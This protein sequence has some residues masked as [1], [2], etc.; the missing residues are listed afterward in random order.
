MKLV[1]NGAEVPKDQYTGA[2]GTQIDIDVVDVSGFGLPLPKVSQQYV[3]TGAAFDTVNSLII[4]NPNGKNASIPVK[5]YEDSCCEDDVLLFEGIIRGDMVDWCYGECQC[6]VT[7]K[8]ETEESLKVQC[9]KSTLIWDNWNGFQTDDHPRIVYCNEIRPLFIQFL[10]GYLLII[11]SLILSALYP[12]VAAMSLVYSFIG[13]VVDAINA[14]GAN[15]TWNGNGF[16]GNNET[17]ILQEYQQW[18]DN[19]QENVIQCGRKHPSPLVRNYIQN[20]C[21]KCGVTFESSI[22]TDPNSDY[23]NA[24]YVNAPIN[25]GT[26]NESIKWIDK[27]RPILMLDGL[28]DQLVPVFNA[29]YRFENGVLRFERKDFFWVGDPFVNYSSLEGTGQIKEKLCLA[30]R[31]ETRPAWLSITYLGDGAD[32]TGNEALGAYRDM[33]EWNNP[34]SNLQSG[35]KEVQIPFSVPRFRNDNLDDAALDVMVNFPFGIGANIQQHANVMTM[36]KGVCF[37]PRLIIWDGDDINFARVKIFDQVLT[38]PNENGIQPT[39]GT[40]KNYALQVNEMDGQGGLVTPNTAYASDQPGMGIYPRFYAWENPKLISDEGL[41]F[42]FSMYYNCD[43]LVASLS[44]RYVQL[45]QG[46][47]RIDKIS[48]NLDDKSL[49]IVGKV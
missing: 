42:T 12:I 32:T 2:N 20:V 31:D 28:L 23:Y 40:L 14:L 19:V 45:P 37:Q 24:V 18:L 48:V 29:E 39:F 36:Q 25:K 1:L 46:I 17:S 16:D 11:L 9:M 26:K 43:S 30:W 15:L 49:T 7:F 22:F 13:I 6:T 10:T 33:I 44:A 35:K 4:E 38:E 21:D 47:G 3:F 27:N 5:I 34:M 8:E 41:E